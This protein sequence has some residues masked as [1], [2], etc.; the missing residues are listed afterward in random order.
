MVFRPEVFVSATPGELDPYRDVVKSTLREIGAHPVEH[1]DRTTTYGPL[2]GVL[3]L[4]I[5][6]CDAVIHLTAFAFGAEP[7]DRTHG[8]T[9][10]SFTHYEYDV[11]RALK[12]EVLSFVARPGTPVSGIARDDEEARA[13]QSAH[14][15]AIEHGGEHWTFA[16][17]DELAELIRSL[18]PR[19]MVR[20]RLA[21]LPFP[22]RGK[23]LAG[24]ERALAE[25][26]DAL[27]ASRVVIIEPPAQF[28]TSSASAGKTALAVEAAWR[29]HESGRYDFVFFIPAATGAEI[30]SELA[31][32]THT[33]ALALIKDEVADHRARLHA[34]RQWLRADSHDGRFLIVL[35]GVD[36]E[37]AWIAVEQMLPW[38]ERGSVIVTTRQPRD[39]TGA[40]HLSL[41][42][43]TAEAS[44]ALLAARLYGR[45]ATAAE[46]RPLEQLAATLGHQPFALQLAARAIADARETPQHLLAAL[47]AEEDAATTTTSPCVGR[48]LPVVARVVRGSIARLDPAARGFL[49]VLA[50]LA[51]QPSA[52][53]QAIFAG[54]TDSTA[55]RT[56]L[57]QLEKLGL[58]AFADDGQSILVHRLVREIVHDRLTPEDAATALDT[59]RTLIEGALDRAGHSP[60]A[61]L[62]R[63]RLVTHCRVLLGQLN[64]HPL[65]LR[66][67]RLARGVASWLRDCGRFSAAENFQ[68]RALAIVERACEPGHP[69]IIPELRLL[70]AILHDARRFDEAAEMH[71]RAIAIIE[72]QPGSHAG[73]LVAELSALAACLRAGGQLREA[74]PAL[75][76]ALEIEERASGRMHARTALAAHTLASLLEV[77]HRPFDAMPLYRR[78][79]EID[80]QL[81][82]CPPTR[83]ASRLHHLATALAACGRR[84]EAI[85]LHERALALDEKAL[86]TQHAELIAPLKHLAAIF[87]LEDRRSDA[88]A[89]LRRVL[90]IEEKHSAPPLELA[91]TLA[92]LAHAVAPPEAEPLC[93]RALSILDSQPAWHPLTRALRW[94]CEALLRN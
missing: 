25:L 43:L 3:K 48:W 47:S 79:L 88:A 83:L 40:A 62:L 1:T 5:G 91:T 46:Q 69:E 26:R 8:A 44:V 54:R 39:I 86:G 20:R 12:R 81:P 73:E 58:I 30:E 84:H 70:A 6:K 55:P 16:G 68:R 59:A 18:R 29:L 33:D 22:P 34:L 71:R 38:F 85:A 74:E 42:S 90:S 36:H 51:P 80:E 24:R 75:R 10:R 31:A 76:R 93:R 66:A 49:H 4:A 9:R 82:V 50:C 78:A 56:A 45:D 27:A 60:A 77:L 67:G 87:E 28:A 94:E 64:G 11:A 53:P 7:P 13:L 89:L 23:L 15:R 14:R 65:E 37:S 57:G 21:R 41:G 35:D 92:S 61:A 52:V 63:T 2:D 72:K 19:I 32:L 17:P